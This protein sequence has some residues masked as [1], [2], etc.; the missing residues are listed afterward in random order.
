MTAAVM[1][2]SRAPFARYAHLRGAAFALIL[3]GFNSLMV[4][5]VATARALGWTA[6][7]RDP[8]FF[9][10]AW[11]NAYVVAWPLAF[12]AVLIVAPVGRQIVRMLFGP[13]EG[14]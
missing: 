1:P 9:R 12:P 2:H 5:G 14:D 7:T 3:S 8:S 11:F 13:T 10:E 6:I 4:S